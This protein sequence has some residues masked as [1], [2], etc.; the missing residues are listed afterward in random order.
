MRNINLS[1]YFVTLSQAV[2]E[3]ELIKITK[4]LNFFNYLYVLIYRAL[5]L[6]QDLLNILLVIHFQVYFKFKI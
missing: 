6:R 2:D 5:I 3:T 1:A 4:S